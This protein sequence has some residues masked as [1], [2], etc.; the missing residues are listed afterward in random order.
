MAD[1]N[2]EL[3][4]KLYSKMSL[5][6]GVTPV[7]ENADPEMK[8]ILEGP[9]PRPS[10]IMFTGPDEAT[11]PRQQDSLLAIYNPGQYL[12]ASLDPEKNLNDRYSLSVLLDVIPQFSWAFKPAAATV[13]LTYRSVLDYKETPLTSLTP[14]QKKKVE[15]AEKVIA[16]D[17]QGYRTYQDAY[18][19]A[20][21]AYQA[22]LATYLNDGPPVPPSLKR[23]VDAAL[24]EWKALGHK[25]RVESAVAVLSA[26]EALEPE[27]FWYK[28]TQRYDSATQMKPDGSEF[29]PVGISPPYKV[30][31]QDA[32]WTSF[33]FSQKDM[34]NQE[35]SQAIG[36]AGSLDGTFGIFRVSGSGEY[37][38][39]AKYVKIDQTELD[40]SG[41]LL[42]VSLDRS[43]MN[44][45][46]FG[47]RAWRWSKSS[48]VFG[49][50]LS[51]GADI[52]GGVAPTGEMTALPTAAILCKDLSIKG[53]FDNTV[54]DQ[55]R[56][57]INAEASVGIGP[58]TVSGRFAMTDEKKTVKG[59]IATNGIEA[60]DVQVIALVCQ[61]VPKCPNPD[62]TLPWPQ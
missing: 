9:V 11:A 20:L 13:S 60:K 26:Y 32:G 51:T 61:L 14:E 38:Q 8:E 46:I 53:S 59:S 48:P 41:K 50:D 52:A 35:N 33:S 28:L 3:F 12:P 31:F 21:D 18:W 23:K 34:D 45:L 44:P 54:V 15:D 56:R 24:T 57:E 27:Q 7:P 30:W 25:S 58:F 4:V 5:A 42:R 39:D 36:V 47:S 37:K 49:V 43:W 2:A 62:N 10:G 29:Q 55:F 22:A 6:L 19:V 1:W 16:A 40:F 17:F